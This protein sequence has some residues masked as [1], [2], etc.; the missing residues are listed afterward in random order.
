MMLLM[1]IQTQ[2]PF[3]V[4]VINRDHE[5]VLFSYSKTHK[6][7]TT[8]FLDKIDSINGFLMPKTL[9]RDIS[10]TTFS[11]SQQAMR[12]GEKE[13]QHPVNDDR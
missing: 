2:Y 4:S 8:L 1:P 7:S 11:K 5:W 6:S 3:M 12:R 9:R 13:A 10:M